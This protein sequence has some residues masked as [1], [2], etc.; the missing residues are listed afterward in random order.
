MNFP[1]LMFE[2]M[3]EFPSVEFLWGFFL[4]IG[5][6]GFL[7]VRFHPV[8]LLPILLIVFLISLG[9]ITDIHSDLYPSIIREAGFKYLVHFYVAMPIGSTILPFLGLIAWFKRGERNNTDITDL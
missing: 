3:G 8:F 4:V 2:V 7:L 9:L 5:V 6:G 1:L